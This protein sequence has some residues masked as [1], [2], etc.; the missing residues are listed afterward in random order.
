[1]KRKD[2]S[3]D[4]SPKQ[5]LQEKLITIANV[6]VDEGIGDGS[7]ARKHIVASL[8]AKSYSP[9]YITDAFDIP[10]AEYNQW[11]D[12]PDYKSIYSQ[13]R[14]M[15]TMSPEKAVELAKA[16]AVDIMGDVIRTA[17]TS[18]DPNAV[19]SAA[20]I[21]LAA[22]K[23]SDSDRPSITFNLTKQEITLIA[24]KLAKLPPLPP[25]DED[26]SG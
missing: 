5:R 14:E 2:A 25:E 16:T 7:L 9:Q 11:Q 12:D 1:M 21:S 26:E 19:L 4:L 3:N 8:T 15:A 23:V 17:H 18:E 10:M 22:S 13:Y 20:K 24:E 6:S